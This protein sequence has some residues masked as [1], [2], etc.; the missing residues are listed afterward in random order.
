MDSIFDSPLNFRLLS[1]L[2]VPISLYYL[3]GIAYRLYISPVSSFPGPRLAALTFAYE[4]YYD[5]VQNG[6]YIWEI[7]RLHEKYGPIVRINPYEIHISDTEFFDTLFSNDR[8]ANKW[9]WSTK[10]FPIELS[11]LST[12]D[13]QKHRMRRGALNQ[14]FSMQRARQLQPMVQERVDMLIKRML[15]CQSTGE[16][17]QAENAFAAMANDIVMQYSFGRHEHRL[18]APAF[19][20]SFSNTS[21]ASAYSLTLWKFFHPILTLVMSLPDCILKLLGDGVAG[22]IT[23]KHAFFEQIEAIRYRK[24]EPELKSTHVTLFHELLSSTLPEQEKTTI[25]LTDE[26]QIIVGAGTETTGWTL[27]IAILHLIDNPTIL[28]TLKEELR[29]IDPD[30][31]GQ[32]S[33]ASLQSLP[34]LS[35]VINESLRLS[36]GTTQRLQRV[37]PHPLIFEPSNRSKT[38][39]IPAGTP[40]SVAIPDIHHN[41]D[42]FPDSYS[43][44]PERWIKD[45]GLA[46]YQMAFSKGSRRCLG[47]NLALAEI[48]TCV[49]A[50]F[51]KFGSKDVRYESDIGILELVD[52]TVDNVRLWGDSFLP[53]QKPGSEGVRIIVIK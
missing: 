9:Y 34:Y 41:E 21:R 14:F 53:L 8:S 4:F 33:L 52:T 36:Y 22:A 35:A 7:Q 32:S 24:N 16:V 43:F 50:V 47:M 18:E 10:M 19:D 13:H 46:K 2:L 37:F 23:M 31:M 45:P 3:Y 20:P 48:Y 12:I 11:L 26:A 5:I 6:Q 1:Y 44:K 51:A 49:A 15:D 30:C 40:I 39:T 17:I 38:W 28:R 42:I 25:R 27:A 29:T